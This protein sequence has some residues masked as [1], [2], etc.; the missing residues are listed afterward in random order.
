MDYWLSCGSWGTRRDTYQ[1]R[2]QKG[3]MQL[4]G[5]DSRFFS[6]NSH[7]ESRTSVNLLS[8]KIKTTTGINESYRERHRPRER[9]TQL[10]RLPETDLQRMQAL[11]ELWRTEDD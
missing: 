4:I 9:W 2:Y 10:A 6:R 11:P 1:F 3:S 7:D 5:A 8:G